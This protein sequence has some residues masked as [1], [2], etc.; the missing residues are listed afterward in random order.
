[1]TDSAEQ[2][3]EASK[4][5][6]VAAESAPDVTLEITAPL[7]HLVLNRPDKRNALSL[8]MWRSLA[9]HLA[10]AN[11]DPSVK[12]ILLRGADNSG[13][14]AGA[15]IAEFDT[16]YGDAASGAAYQQTI[17]ETLSAF[18]A[19][20]KPVIAVIQGSCLGGGCSLA[21]ACDLRLADNTARFAMTPALL[22]I[23]LDAG[24]ARRLTRALG[25]SAAK[26]LLFSARPIKAHEA[27]KI[28]LVNRIHEPGALL[29]E[30]R[31]YAEAVASHSQ[32][33]VRAAKTLI[34]LAA[35]S[36]PALEAESARLSQQALAGPDFQEGI[37]AFKE[38]R[39]AKFSY[40]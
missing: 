11:A 2:A 14:A 8:A 25:P 7:A 15:D 34:D 19:S 4:E 38:K 39:R 18:E 36:D 29:V 10:T 32:F 3:S 5:Q 37:A 24:D 9:E 21:L 35:R 12:V 28:G 27:E 40:S 16:V 23:G 17:T 13:F 26:D 22:G 33:S 6:D 30:A 31:K 1:M 20:T